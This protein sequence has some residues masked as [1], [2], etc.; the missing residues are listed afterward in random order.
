MVSMKYVDSKYITHVNT[1]NIDHK[2]FIFYP[3][4]VFTKVRY[5]MCKNANKTH[6]SK[7]IEK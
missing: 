1:I 7:G 4:F 6:D 3:G 5:V 2:Q